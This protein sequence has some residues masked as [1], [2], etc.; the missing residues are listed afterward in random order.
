[1]R[2]KKILKVTGISLLVLVVLLAL[3]VFAFI[4]NPFEGSVNDLRDLVPRSSEFYVR[5]ARLDGDFPRIGG[6]SRFPEPM[7]WENLTGTEEWMELERG[8]TY[9]ALIAAGVADLV[10]GMVSLNQELPRATGGWVDL[11]GDLMGTEVILAGRSEDFDKNPLDRA[12]VCG[13]SRVTWK[14][15][16]GWGLAQWGSVQSSVAQ[17]GSELVDDEGM[18]RFTPA[19]GE[20][21]WLHREK[22]CLMFSTGREF[23]VEV[24]KLVNGED[25]VESLAQASEYQTAIDGGIERWIRATDADTPNVLEFSARPN[26]LPFFKEFSAGWPDP[27]HPDSMNQR[28]LARFLRLAGWSFVN[29]AL[30]FEPDQGL[31]LVG[32]VNLDSNDHTPFQRKFYRAEA[33]PHSEWLD[34]FIDMVPE[35]ACAAL[36]FRM[37]ASEFLGEM[38]R[39]LDPEEQSLLDEAFRK[40][41]VFQSTLDAISSVE[42]SLEPRVG[43]I[44]RESRPDTAPDRPTVAVPSPAPHLA[45]VF[46]IQDGMRKPL[47]D[48]VDAMRMQMQA[49]RFKQVM[50]IDM[51]LAQA[52]EADFKN[53]AL[54]F[55]QPQVPG[56]GEIA[57]LIFDRFFIV[58]NSG[59][60]IKDLLHTRFLSDGYRSVRDLRDFRDLEEELPQK[61][62]GFI[63]LNG[64]QL[65]TVM[66]DFQ[67]FSMAESATTPNPDFM[68]ANRP[69]VM[70]DVRARLY[71]QYPTVESIPA[72]EKPAFEQAV[73][74]ALTAKWN[75]ERSQYTAEDRASFRETKAMFDLLRMGSIVFELEST[76]I[77][78]TAHLLFDF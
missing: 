6:R 38:Y 3:F 36:A 54:E 30:I 65:S 64:P 18:L 2:G 20:P 74:E 59:P 9:Q 40:T 7:F 34:P 33:R 44:F 48:F 4:F 12:W 1:M 27:Q 52:V 46:W 29:G 61:L 10:E 69:T 41:N 76:R 58:S 17:N 5:K 56:T 47:D 13:F 60:F 16:A 39:S 37:P 71:S 31:G 19:G 42:F 62:S 53:S 24:R 68:I 67:A 25:G 43:M 55:Y 15:R 57:T 21:I 26:K 28:V 49:F 73:R 11:L 51:N 23:L 35:D 77:D 63:Y 8:P 78:L 22:D 70:S 32:Q 72:G 50:K 14:V 45:W 75:Q 66:D